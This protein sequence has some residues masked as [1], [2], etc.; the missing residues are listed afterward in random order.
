MA[1]GDKS[2]SQHGYF[3]TLPLDQLLWVVIGISMTIQ[4]TL[5]RILLWAG[6]PASLVWALGISIFIGLRLIPLNIAQKVKEKHG[7]P[8]P[9][10]LKRNVFQRA[11]V[12]FQE[13]LVFISLYTFIQPLDRFVMPLLE[14]IGQKSG[15]QSEKKSCPV[16]LLHGFFCNS[17]F[18]LPT[19]LYLGCMGMK[20]IYTLS[21]IPALGDIRDYSK[22]LSQKVCTH[23]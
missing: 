7:S 6:V 8:Y 23:Q 13:Y 11:G 21:L 10:H 17:I 1:E 16:I 9:A 22:Q 2:P 20:D 12:L 3:H 18:W 19:R 5:A 15:V 4:L 14:R